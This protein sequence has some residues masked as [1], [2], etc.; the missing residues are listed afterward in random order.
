MPIRSLALPLLLCTI[1]SVGQLVAQA[2]HLE[3]R[4]AATQL[5]ADGQPFLMLSG[6]LTN[7]SSSSLAYMQPIW[8]KL[9]AAGLNTIV[10]PLSWELIEPAEGKFDF[11]LVDGLLAQ[12]REQHLKVVFLWL[13]SWK[14]GMS[15]YPPVWVKQDTK[16]FPRVMLNGAKVDVLSPQSQSTR[17][18]DSRAFAA[19]MAHIKAVDGTRHTVLAMQVENEVGILNDSRDRSPDADAAFAAA[20]PAELTR[21]LA[22]HKAELYPELHSLWEGQGAKTSGTWTEVFGPGPRADEIFMAWQYARFVQAVTAAGKAAYDLPMYVNCW[23]GGGDAKPGDY[24]SGGPQPRVV[25]IWKAAAPPAGPKIDIYAPDLYAAD[26]EGWSKRYHRDGNPLFI[27]ETNSGPNGAANVFYAVGEHAAICFSPFAIERALVRDAAPDA[28]PDAKP[29]QPGPRTPTPQLSAS[30]NVIAQLWPLLA[31]AQAKGESH[32]FLL[33]KDHPIADF[34]INGYIAHVSLDQI[35]GFHAEKGFGLIFA[36]GPDTFYGAGAGFRVNFTLPDGK[37]Q[38]GLAAIDEGVF[39]NG[40]W[41]AGR[42]LNGDES[43]QG[44]YWRVDQSQTKIEK[45]TVYQFQ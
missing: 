26:F 9:A 3:T 7:S 1:L 12:A 6:E 36:A 42:R 10:T 24:P 18:A 22:A 37:A 2:P 38:V 17:E 30:Y 33:D 35:F 8:P 4:G 23:L 43:D 34:P 11:T 32:G 45:A 16:R 13:A 15:S 31:A 44:N 29:S 41:I 39:T 21:Y 20:V 28:A 14:N 5:I 19:L 40:K 25:D 27:P